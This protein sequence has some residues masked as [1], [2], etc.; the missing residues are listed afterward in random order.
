MDRTNPPLFSSVHSRDLFTAAAIYGVILIAFWLVAEHIS[1][2]ARIG[3]MGSTFTAFALVFA[4]YWFFGFGAAEALQRALDGRAPR[5]LV[6]AL[7][8]VP[9]LVYAS[10]RGE[11]RWTYFFAFL[12]VPMGISALFAFR[13]PARTGP[14][15]PRLGWQD[16]AALAA[17]G[18]P[19]EFNWLR[20]AF[21]HDGLSALP[22]LLLVDAGLYAFLVVRELEGVGY[23]FRPRMRDVLTGLRELVFF[24]PIVIVLGMALRFI[25]PHGGLPGAATALQDLL[26]TFFFVAVP[27]ELFF[28]GWL[29][30]LLEGRLGRQRALG[31]AAAIFGLSHFNKPL[32]FNWRYVLI[33]TFAGVFYGRAWRE[34]RR[35]LASASTHTLVDVLWTLWFR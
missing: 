7:L 27:E 6:A 24:A 18:L 29:Q 26:V 31:I 11:F 28:R 15:G 1:L 14:A 20:G 23:D 22:K 33:A 13:P 19:V 21:P 30:N 2:G 35:L 8:V 9:Y 5:V 12:A 16:M 4:P 34:R 25:R 3:Y 32:P 10:P 17:V